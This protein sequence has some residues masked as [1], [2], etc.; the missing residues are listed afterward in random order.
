MR[1]GRYSIEVDEEI[2]EIYGNLTIEEAYDFINFFDK[3]GYKTLTPGSEN[4]TIRLWK[5][6]YHEHVAELR[7]KENLEDE[8]MYHDFFESE[9]KEHQKTKNKLE[10]VESLVNLMFVEESDKVKTLKA[11]IDVLEKHLK[12]TKL[13]DNP[14]FQKI[15]NSFTV[16]PPIP[17][18]AHCVDYLC[19]DPNAIH[20]DPMEI[21]S[22]EENHAN[23]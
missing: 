21:P 22:V 1:E 3:K 11:K 4:S 20:R 15:L 6:D 9:K 17:E 19:H 23:E 13:A 10:Q 2:V 14:E 16:A 18:S 12:Q 7:K 8:T 5:K